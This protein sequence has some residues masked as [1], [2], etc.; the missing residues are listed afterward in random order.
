MLSDQQKTAF[1]NQLKQRFM[2]LREE[3]SRELIKSDNE[4]Y[5]DLAGKVHD[6]EEASVADLLVDLQL[7]TIDREVNEIRDIDAALLRIAHGSFGICTDC[8]I[9]IDLKRLQALSTAKRCQRCQV[10]YE[11]THFPGKHSS[12]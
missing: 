6:I 4:H 8:D 12:I 2:A 10:A 1:R 9:P 11:K 3:I 5:I 7:A